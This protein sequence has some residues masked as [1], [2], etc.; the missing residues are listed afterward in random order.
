MKL[1]KT[2]ILASRLTESRCQN[3]ADPVRSPSPNIGSPP[4][5]ILRVE[6]MSPPREMNIIQSTTMERRPKT[7][8]NTVSA[9]A[10]RFEKA[11]TVRSVVTPGIMRIGDLPDESAGNHSDDLRDASKKT[12]E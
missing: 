10:G 4:F 6:S 7:A 11:T 5:A 2:K 8:R 9:S 3:F 1:T 12:S